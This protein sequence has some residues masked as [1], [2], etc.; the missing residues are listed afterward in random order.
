LTNILTELSKGNKLHTQKLAEQFET[1]IRIIQLDFKEYIIPLFKEDT[2]SY[3]YSEKCYF[4]KKQFLQTS[5]L[6]I[7]EL[8]TIAILKNKSR[9]K[10]VDKELTLNTNLLIEKLEDS[11]TNSIYKLPSIENIENN[12]IDIV[13]VKNAIKTKTKIE[14]IYNDKKRELYP[15]Q[16]LNLD[17]FWYLINYDLEYDEIRRYHLNSIK[18]VKFLEIE[19]EFDEE[20]ISGFDNAI[21]A[22]FEPHIKPF[23]VE[24]FLDNKV[25]KYFLRKPINKTQRVLKTYEDNSCD[26]EIYITDFMEIIP[27]IQ[28]YLPYIMVISPIEL[29][30]T[31][32]TNLDE[33]FLKTT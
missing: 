1:T 12:K 23:V 28:S 3:N 26:I 6:N 4:A 22:Y 25:S 20:I 15:L 8:V 30:K 33:Y 11:L 24:L 2:I 19:F 14:C 7:E 32:K 16:I 27:L 10:Y 29:N 9:D 5:L 21:N 17:S 18:E 31:I 13:K